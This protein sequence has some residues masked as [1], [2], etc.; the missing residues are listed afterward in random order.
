MRTDSSWYHDEF[1]ESESSSAIGPLSARAPARG[2][3]NLLLVVALTFYYAGGAVT[4]AG[5]AKAG[6]WVLSGVCLGLLVS[7]YRAE[8]R[9][10]GHL[11]DFSRMRMQSEAIEQDDPYEYPP[12]GL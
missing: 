4:L 2:H 10:E 1:P 12:P 11:A 7:E 3:Y 9:V 6:V 5:L 8:K